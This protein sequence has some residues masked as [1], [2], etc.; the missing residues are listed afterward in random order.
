MA[1][2]VQEAAEALVALEVDLRGDK[3][4]SV[5]LA[6]EADKEAGELNAR[7]RGYFSRGIV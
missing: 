4:A 6:G 3:V 2:A 1:A 7:K 5:A